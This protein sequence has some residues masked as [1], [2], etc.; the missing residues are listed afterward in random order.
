MTSTQQKSFQPT[1]S[2]LRDSSGYDDNTERVQKVVFLRHG[3]ARHNLMDPTTGQPPNLKDPALWDP[4]LVRD[5]RLQAVDAGERLQIWWKTTQLGETVELI[6]VSPLTRCLQTAT[7]A[8]LP[9]SLY[10][11]GLKEPRF[12]CD[13][14]VREAFGKH[15]PDRRRGKSVLVVRKI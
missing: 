2:A 14:Q 10:T 7:L 13:E 11:N 6:L 9:G 1:A 3:V 15:Y 5:G 4:P 8:F 12:V